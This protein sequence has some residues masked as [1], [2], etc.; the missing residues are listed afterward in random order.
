MF[1]GVMMAQTT[2]DLRVQ[3]NDEWPKT[4]LFP[5]EQSL[6]SLL[7]QK[8]LVAPFQPVLLR[9]IEDPDFH[10]LLASILDALD[11]LPLRPDRT[12]EALWTTLDREIALK[13][14]RAAPV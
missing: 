14:H 9:N 12:F 3:F 6:S 11:A 10:R 5:I 7:H 13:L 8:G 4:F 1:P 2:R